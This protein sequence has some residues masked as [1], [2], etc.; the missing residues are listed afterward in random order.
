MGGY[1][2]EHEI[3]LKSGMVVYNTLK[4]YYNCYRILIE[5]NSWTLIDKNEN[6]KEIDKESF[7]VI[8]YPNLIFDCI[9]NAIHGTPGE[10]GKMQKYFSDKKIPITGS[11]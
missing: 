5:E 7:Q 9:F 1:S 10:D 3:S 4:E 6:L 2:H 8:D 11:N